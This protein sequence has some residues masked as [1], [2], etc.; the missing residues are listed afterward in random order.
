MIYKLLGGFSP[1][2]TVINYTVTLQMCPQIACENGKK[3]QKP[4]VETT[5]YQYQL[6]RSN[7][8]FLRIWMLGPPSN[9][10]IDEA[11]GRTIKRCRLARRFSSKAWE[12]GAEATRQTGEF[13]I[14]GNNPYT[15]LPS[16]KSNI[17]MGSLKT[18][19]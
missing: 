9:L 4:W 13:G 17:A 3:Q 18:A 6:T 2:K 5:C 14:T 10:G 11:P 7:H 8:D 15:Q 1:S 16:K 19:M 12:D